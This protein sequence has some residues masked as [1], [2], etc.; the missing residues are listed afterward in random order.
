MGKVFFLDSKSLLYCDQLPEVIYTFDCFS[1]IP[2]L[3]N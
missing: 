3:L 2:V 1:I